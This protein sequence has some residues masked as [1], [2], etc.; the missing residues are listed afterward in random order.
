M[1]HR[2]V[3]IA[4]LQRSD[5]ALVDSGEGVRDE[6][7]EPGLVDLD[8]ECRAALADTILAGSAA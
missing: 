8:V 3:G 1:A 7:V 2:P 5:L 4:D 6:R